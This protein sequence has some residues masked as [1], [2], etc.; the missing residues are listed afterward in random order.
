MNAL[1]LGAAAVAA[2]LLAKK[3]SVSG[4]GAVD[5]KW[6]VSNI[7]ILI[8]NTES[9]YYSY[10]SRI[11]SYLDKGLSK[12]NIINN[13]EY[14]IR[15]DISRGSIK[16]NSGMGKSYSVRLEAAKRIYKSFLEDWEY[17]KANA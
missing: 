8:L 9:L 15:L 12:E 10:K 11:Y 3:K 14:L 1:L 5:N 13:I 2:L 4:V 6:G 17:D 16:M 7:V